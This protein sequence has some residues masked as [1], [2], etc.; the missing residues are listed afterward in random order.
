MSGAVAAAASGLVAAI[1]MSG[2]VWPLWGGWSVGAVAAI[3]VVVTGLVLGAVG[4]WRSRDLPGQDWRRD[5]RAWKSTLDVATVS[6]VHAIIGGILAIIVFVAL[7]RSFEG[8]V[9]DGLTATG[10]TAASAGLAGY[11]IYLSVSAITT[12]RLATLLV[13]FMAVATLA[14]MATAQ[15]PQ[16]WE[17]HFSQL[18]TAEDF[19][20]GLFNLALLVA[21]AFVT[22]FALYVHRDLT[23]LVRQG[24]LA[25][26]WA[27]RF[28]SVVFVVMG[29]MLAGVGVFPLTVSV[30]LHNSCAIGMS[31]SFLA[32]LVSSPWT[33]KGLPARFFWF[34]AGA[35][36]LLIGGAVLFEPVGYYN[37]T[38][39]ELLAFATIFGWIAVF[40]RFANALADGRD[41]SASATYSG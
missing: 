18:G 21:G 32:L 19:S 16:W 29:V 2:Q 20:S 13:I 31:L 25:N 28:V 36:L 24:V 11:W 17:Y 23:T 34:C 10:A 1:V 3:A 38:A 9:V 5:L 12:N 6:A 39:F 40:I 41:T 37:L 33:L 35:G 30:A 27:P 4:Y 15:D 7:Q 14:S 22:T 8:L 26:A